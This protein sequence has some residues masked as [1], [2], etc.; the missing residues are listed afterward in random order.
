VQ[1]VHGEADT[2][3][4]VDHSVRIFDALGS[5]EKRLWIIPR[6]SHGRGFRRARREYRE[7]LVTFFREA[8]SG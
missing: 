7:R 6:A 1:I 2:M 5:H 3:I 4:D 8:L